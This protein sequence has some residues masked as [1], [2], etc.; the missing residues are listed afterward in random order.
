MTS[1]PRY[2]LFMG[3]G[4]DGV[5]GG[6]G[7][8]IS[9]LNFTNNVNGGKSLIATGDFNGDGIQ[10]VLL[11]NT[12]TGEG[13][14]SLRHPGTHRC[15]LYRR[16]P[17]H[18]Q[19]RRHRGHDALHRRRGRR[20]DER[21]GGRPQRRRTSISW[22]P[23][24]RPTTSG[25]F[26]N[27]GN[28]TFTAS[29]V[30]LPVSP[31]KH[32]RRGTSPAP[33]ATDSPC[34]RRQPRRGQRRPE[35]P[36]LHRAERRHGH[37]DRLANPT[38]VPASARTSQP[39]RSTTRAARTFSSACN[40]AGSTRYSTPARRL[41]G[42]AIASSAPWASSSLSRRSASSRAAAAACLLASGK[43]VYATDPSSTVSC[44]R[45]TSSPCKPTAR[46]TAP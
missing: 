27:H 40:R 43:N 29:A 33:A 38:L 6:K 13:T 30:A 42:R 8:S 22:C 24:L 37:S 16:P 21:R 26:I 28:G 31:T 7:G 45:S 9:T 35:Q 18:D 32:R 1:S 3:H 44:P 19:P 20:A 14:L 39:P 4:G 34:S 23:T 11:I 15:A 5:T 12:V 2:D 25:V 46:R 10:D 17:T 41:P 36:G